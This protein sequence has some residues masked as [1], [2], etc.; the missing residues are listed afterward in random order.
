MVFPF[1][2]LLCEQQKQDTLLVYF[3]SVLYDE[4]K[5]ASDFQRAKQT[6]FFLKY[7]Q[8]FVSAL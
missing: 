7:A 1:F 3:F 2:L 5:H 4:L 8:F 6:L